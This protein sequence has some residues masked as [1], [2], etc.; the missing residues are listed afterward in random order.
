M[1]SVFCPYL[2]HLSTSQTP[3]RS[4]VA[5]KL[6]MEEIRL[7]T[8]P[9]VILV[10]E[11]QEELGLYLCCSTTIGRYVNF[12]ISYVCCWL[13][14]EALSHL[15]TTLPTPLDFFSLFTPTCSNPSFSQLLSLPFGLIYLYK[16]VDLRR[17]PINLI[18]T[19]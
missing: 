8:R 2:I 11:P 6:F 18:S 12:K 3:E 17:H 7:S 5:R 13:R 15:K 1:S 4:I 10:F 14:K 9:Q 19:R 16:A